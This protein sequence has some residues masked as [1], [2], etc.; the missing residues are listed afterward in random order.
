MVKATATTPSPS[1]TLSSLSLSLSRSLKTRRN[2]K[3]YR[4]HDP[5][6]PPFG[7]SPRRSE[8]AVRFV[9]VSSSSRCRESSRD[10][11]DE[12]I[13]AVPLLTDRRPLPTIHRHRCSSG[14]ADSSPSTAVSSRARRCSPLLPSLSISFRPHHLTV[15]R[16]CFCSGD[17][18]QAAPPL[19]GSPQ[20][21]LSNAPSRGCWDTVVRRRRPPEALCQPL[22][23]GNDVEPAWSRVASACRPRGAT[24]ALTWPGPTCQKF[25]HF[26][27]Y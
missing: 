25:K 7:A 4:R 12:E 8:T 6:P 18:I 5:S 17:H 27:K 19:G 13:D 23:R 2:P 16:R 15:G 11:P 10:A 22:R 20:P 1:S 26:G 3:P 9:V 24:V 21:P 14:L